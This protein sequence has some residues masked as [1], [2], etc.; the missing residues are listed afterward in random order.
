MDDSIH[1]VGRVVMIGRVCRLDASSLIDRNIDDNGSLLHQRKHLPGDHLGCFRA[2][3]ENAPHDDI[4]LGDQSFDVMT[5]GHYDFDL[6]PEYIIQ[7]AEPVD[8][9]IEDIDVR[10]RTHCHLC[11]IGAHHT[12]TEDNH[13]ARVDAGDTTEQH[14]FA[15]MLFLQGVLAYLDR[16][17][18]RHLAHRDKERERSIFK[19]NSFVGNSHN[20]GLQHG[21]R[22]VGHRREM[23]IGEDD[24]TLLKQR[25][26]G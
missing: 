2:R 18:P 3:H 17:A 10:A 12:S 22:E 7:V 15:T 16:H 24:L 13:R 1:D 6:A 23:K 8:I 14:P 25:I 21:L 19:L 9:D 5:I 20:S 4:R 26:F 11:R